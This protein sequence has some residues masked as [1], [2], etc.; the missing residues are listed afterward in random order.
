[1]WRPATAYHLA[2][3]LY[4]PAALP[5]PPELRD[6]PHH[7]PSLGRGIVVGRAM[8][9]PCYS[10]RGPDHDRRRV[11]PRSSF[12]ALLAAFVSTPASAP[13]CCACVHAWVLVCAC[14]RVR[15]RAFCQGMPSS[16]APGAGCW[17]SGL[18]QGGGREMSKGEEGRECVYFCRA[19]SLVTHGNVAVLTVI[20]R[21]N[22]RRLLRDLISLSRS[23]AAQASFRASNRIT[24]EG[25]GEG[26][27]WKNGGKRRAGSYARA[28]HLEHSIPTATILRSGLNRYM[29]SL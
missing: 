3:A 29:R 8:R 25:E 11:T 27:G 19:K 15:A 6:H 20:R 4:E 28:L 13:A 23:R 24:C 12:P 9:A 17:I 2:H 7:R 16:V 5:T 1:M 10:D 26:Q 21:V 18:V 22:E 14:A